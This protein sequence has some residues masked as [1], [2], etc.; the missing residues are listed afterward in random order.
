MKQK[1]TAK[2]EGK[3]V[4]VPGVPEFIATADSEASDAKSPRFEDITGTEIPWDAPSGVG[5][6]P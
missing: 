5:T 1:V 4:C 6:T 3:R 2:G